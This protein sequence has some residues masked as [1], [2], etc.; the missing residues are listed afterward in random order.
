MK[1]PSP[2]TRL[3]LAAVAVVALTPQSA[4]AAF[5]AESAEIWSARSQRIAEAV[6]Q[7]V[8]T[9]DDIKE[10]EAIGNRY[11]STV[12]QACTGITGEHIRYGGKNMPVWAQTAQQHF[13][14]GADNLFRAYSSGKKDKGYCRDLKSSIGYARKAKAGEDP[15]SVVQ[16]AQ[17]LIGAAEALIN[18]KITLQKWSVLGTSNLSFAC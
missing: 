4:A 1:S 13:C 2:I 17:A 5:G 12:K 15:E 8:A 6:G 9:S 16:A 18:T 14:L 3:V 10:S 11:F 7:T